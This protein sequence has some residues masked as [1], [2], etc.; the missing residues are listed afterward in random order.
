MTTPREHPIIF[1]DESILAILSRRKFET[2]RVVNPQ[3]VK[4]GF[5][6]EWR[7]AGWS[8]ED[9]GAPA[10][11]CHSLATGPFG[12]RGHLLWVREAWRVCGVDNVDHAVT[13]QYRS[14]MSMV[15]FPLVDRWYSYIPKIGTRWRPSIHMPRWASRLTLRVVAV[16]IDRLQTITGSAAKLEGFSPT[17]EKSP[18]ML[19]AEA[20][21][22]I[23]G[24][25]GW[26]LE[27]NPWV[28]VVNFRLESSARGNT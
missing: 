4:R 28:W 23:Y 26:P 16:H 10:M 12:C 18:R 3:P 17:R 20:W 24:P 5:F 11:P 2:R 13:V 8:R 27:S 9:I 19:F 25:R 7:G 6:W 21:N 22:R 1:N 14:D 15:R